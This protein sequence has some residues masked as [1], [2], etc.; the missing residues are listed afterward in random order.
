MDIILT[1][2]EPL[3]G[4]VYSGVSNIRG[5]TVAPLGIERIELLVNGVFQTNIPSGGRRS[6]VGAEFPNFP[7][8]DESG[9]AMAF[10][11]S[12]LTE[13][14]N[15]ITLRAVDNNGDS[16]EVSVTF[17]I[18]RFDKSF[19]DDPTKI[20]LTSESTSHDDSSIFIDEMI[21]DGQSYDVQLGWRT[22]T[23]GFAITQI[24]SGNMLSNSEL[25]TVAAFG[26][27]AGFSNKPSLEEQ[28]YT[29]SM[30]TNQDII[31]TVEEPL[32]ASVYSGVSNIRGWAIAPLGIER[33]ELL[34]NGEFL[35]N[36][37]SGGRRSDVGDAFPGFPNSDESGFAMAFNY[38]N[39]MAGQNNITLRAVDKNN[40]TNEV[41]VTFNT[42]RFT[43]SFI[44]DST[45]IS[46]ANASI[47]NNNSSIF[48]DNMTADGQNYDVRFDWRTATQGFAI[49]Q[50]T[51]ADTG[52]S[53]SCVDI[54]G[55]WDV[56]E[57]ATADCMVLGQSEKLTQSA[58]GQVDIKQDGCNI[59][60]TVPE[61]D[62]PRVG[63]IDG[64]NISYT[65]PLVIPFLDN[66][67]FAENNVSINGMV[68]GNRIELF[69]TGKA[70]GTIDDLPF[71][72]T[73]NS[74][75]IFTR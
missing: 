37:P 14:Q 10:N 53:P 17:N 13:G 46:L 50:I 52:P 18:T 64:N 54:A 45:K 29:V 66:V 67:E 32:D 63:T 55:F 65:G 71:S 28:P 61:V 39:L 2:E 23:Q 57:T 60:Y 68:N 75:S 34:I 30:A 70:S 6:D 15:L 1:V 31:L 35:T 49:T 8:S 19:I 7:N 3:D 22:A 59:S 69:G 25:H 26:S 48:V 16:N 72:C 62:I 24:T 38:S 74:T 21:A 58:M 44:N 5:W 20:N 40:D 56:I 33:I 47:S 36:I 41:S 11:Y 4:S 27:F 12:N 9:F 43:N 73:G 51:P 42:T